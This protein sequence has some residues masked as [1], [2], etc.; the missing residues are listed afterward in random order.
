MD[1][2]L[3]SKLL[4][5]RSYL[6]AQKIKRQNKKWWKSTEYWKVVKI[7]SIKC[8]LLDNQNQ[9]KFEVWFIFISNKFCAY[10]LNFEPRNIVFLKTY[11]TVYN[12]IAIKFMDQK[13]KP[14]QT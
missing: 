8:N 13:D 14:L 10:L 2:S 4:K 6:V 1:I 7:V 5:P 3:N 11:N 9:Q 12:D